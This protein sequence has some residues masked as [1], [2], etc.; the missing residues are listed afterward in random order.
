MLLQVWWLKWQQCVC[1]RVCSTAQHSHAYFSKYT[2]PVFWS[3]FLLQPLGSGVDGRS[4]DLLITGA[5][6]I[7]DMGDTGDI[8]DSPLCGPGGSLLLEK[9]SCNV[10]FGRISSTTE[11]PAVFNVFTTCVWDRPCNDCPFTARIS[12]PK[13]NDF[14]GITIISPSHFYLC[15][16]S[17]APP[18]FIQEMTT[19]IPCSFPPLMLKS[20]PLFLRCKRTVL[21]PLEL[22]I[23]G[24]QLQ[25]G[26]VQ[27]AGLDYKR[28]NK[29]RQ[30]QTSRWRLE[31]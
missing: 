18:S 13:L 3:S 9:M 11:A 23:L 12:S 2:R 26:G 14:A 1:V 19:P 4:E 22:I 28:C 6:D 17:P 5:G 20:N 15:S 8:G 7:G 21:V 30:I 16:S 10:M 27:R 31:T 25:G 29:R 24:L